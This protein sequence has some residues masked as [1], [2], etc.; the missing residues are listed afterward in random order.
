LTS[1]SGP[2]LD[3]L[4]TD[5]ERWNQFVGAASPPSFLQ[6]TPWAVSKRPNGWT[7]HRIVTEGSEGPIGA[8]L[9]VR[10][11]GPLPF[12]FGYAARGPLAGAPPEA[13]GLAAF[14]AEVR[15]VAR[16]VGASY[17]RIDP[18]L[19]DADGS[20]AGTL[21]AL[22]WRQVPNVLPA[23]TSLIDLSAPEDQIWQAIHRK[24]RQSITKS[25]RDGAVIV[26]AGIDR[27]PD[28]HRVYA[29]TMRRV[30]LAT[31]SLA[32]FRTLYEAFD[33]DGHVHLFLATGPDGSPIA[34]LLLLGWGTRVAD[35]Y[36]GTTDVGRQL[37][38]NYSIKW[39]A[40]RAAKARGY[41]GYD[42]WGLPSDAVNQFK[43][44]W[45]GRDVHYVGTWDLVVNPVGRFMIE[46][47]IRARGQWFRRRGGG[48][49]ELSQFRGL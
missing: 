49:A 28:F 13:A 37:R 48:S 38:A 43:A 44:G 24:T 4:R 15:S 33:A 25:G 41:T 31:R 7:A 26:A 45:G 3:D 46:A 12:G 5:D 36:G 11:P 35:L 34:A 6:A 47:G 17:V 39:E 42:L 32:S 23:S 8:Q 19:E 29:E 27:L 16:D 1:S 40:I 2:A 22:G 20:V 10:R 30:G 18:E 9:L 14:T 21:A